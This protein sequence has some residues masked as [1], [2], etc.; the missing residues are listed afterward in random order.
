MKNKVTLVR[1]IFEAI[2]RDID[3]MNYSKVRTLGHIADLNAIFESKVFSAF[4]DP[5][6]RSDWDEL[7]SA[8]QTQRIREV[9][10][11]MVSKKERIMENVRAFQEKIITRV[12]LDERI[13][14]FFNTPTL[15]AWNELSTGLEERFADATLFGPGVLDAFRGWSEKITGDGDELMFAMEF[16]LSHRFDF[17]SFLHQNFKIKNFNY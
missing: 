13:Q 15:K 16:N 11:S 10:T 9:L 12:S 7:N 5:I 6:Y 14:N 2:E 3:D 8:E 1:E 17:G 4:S